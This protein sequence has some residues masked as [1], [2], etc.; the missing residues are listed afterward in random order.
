MDL[1]VSLDSTVRVLMDSHWR[2]LVDHGAQ[3]MML[4][5]QVTQ[6]M[7]QEFKLIKMMVLTQMLV[8]ETL[9]LRKTPP[10]QLSHS[11]N[12]MAP[13]ESR[14]LTARRANQCQCALEINHQR[15][16]RVFKLPAEFYQNVMLKMIKLSHQTAIEPDKW[17]AL[18]NKTM[19]L[20][21]ML[22]KET[23]KPRK[24]VLKQLLHS[25]LAMDLMAQ[26]E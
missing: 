21:L 15:S 24:M 17:R 8:K 12:A 26:R 22:V 18:P 23:S 9:W 16:K 5:H 2:L 25:Q 4:T 19:L 3:W 7:L 1:M 20:L 6:D 14:R 10:K 13:T 11:Q